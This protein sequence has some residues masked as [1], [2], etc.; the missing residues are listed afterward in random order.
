M[1]LTETE[2]EG[3]TYRPFKTEQEAKKSA[4][5][6]FN[7]TKQYCLI[8]KRRNYIVEQIYQWPKCFE[9]I[10]KGYYTDKNIVYCNIIEN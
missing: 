8:V 5:N 3:I 10:G 1:I 7:N 9:K 2:F 4:E 6:I